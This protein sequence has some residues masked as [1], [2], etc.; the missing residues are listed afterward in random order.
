[1]DSTQ[2]WPFHQFSEH[3]DTGRPESAK[4]AKDEKFHVSE[5]MK[6]LL[7]LPS[8]DDWD[9]EAPPY[10]TTVG[11]PVN[12]NNHIVLVGKF[13][14]P[15]G[16][17]RKAVVLGTLHAK[18]VEHVGSGDSVMTLPSDMIPGIDRT[19]AREK[20]FEIVNE[21]LEADAVDGEYG[22][23]PKLRFIV[24]FRN[25]M[26]K[27][28]NRFRPRSRKWLSDSGISTNYEV[29]IEDE[30][31]ENV[32]QKEEG[33][34]E[35][36]FESEDETDEEIS[37]SKLDMSLPLV[38]G[39]G[40][41][42]S[43]KTL[44]P[45]PETCP[46][47][48]LN[49][50][51]NVIP[52]LES[53]PPS[54]GKVWKKYNELLTEINKETE[55]D[56]EEWTKTVDIPAKPTYDL[57][58]DQITC[59]AEIERENRTIKNGL[60]NLRDCASV[61]SNESV[62]RYSGGFFDGNG[63]VHNRPPADKSY[64]SYN[65]NSKFYKK[66]VG[67][68]KGWVEVGARGLRGKNNLQDA[69][70]IYDDVATESIIQAYDAGQELFGGQYSESREST[71]EES[72]EDYSG[73]TETPTLDGESSSLTNDSSKTSE[74]TE[75]SSSSNSK[76]TSTSTDST[77]HSESSSEVISTKKSSLSVATSNEQSSQ[78]SAAN[79]TPI[80]SSD[81]SSESHQTDSGSSSQKSTTVGASLTKPISDSSSRSKST[82]AVSNSTNSGSA[83]SKTTN[84]ENA[85]SSTNKIRLAN[86][87]IVVAP[88][89]RL[90]FQVLIK[91]PANLLLLMTKH[92]K[93]LRRPLATA[94]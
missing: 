49:N 91:R 78:S 25:L 12:V 90:S 82:S 66:L 28:R 62:C 65:T 67:V 92:L 71:E 84:S 94:N 83:S 7:R 38:I 29:N 11:R 57:T 87:L 56:K 52:T 69:E 93:K 72:T 31:E 27:V 79:S 36:G 8:D 86:L 26:R 76:D 32:A 33:A 24:P 47:E 59:E 58:I 39:R 85:S 5:S 81:Q 53:K 37:L 4:P 68:V 89:H 61:S 80:V 18:P 41:R 34:F 9:G 50:T 20:G 22:E 15:D 21:D 45:K 16:T 6:Q 23:P 88:H 77:S 30:I 64:Y 75:S 44:C 43:T 2:A 48:T 60:R 42:R 70:N 55:K 63:G 51:L 13:K 73:T 46:Y 19:L 35:S 3:A 17:V 14:N 1:M 74:T 54:R 40:K 10:V